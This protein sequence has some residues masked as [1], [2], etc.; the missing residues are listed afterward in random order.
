MTMKLYVVGES[1]G[2]PEDWSEWP[3]RSLVIA[4]SSEEA[5]KLAGKCP[6]E[7]VSEVSMITPCV[8]FTDESGFGDYLQ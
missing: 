7:T 2:N 1:S 8:L 3:L 5:M 6:P 4:S